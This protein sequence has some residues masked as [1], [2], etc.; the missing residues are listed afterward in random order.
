M[1]RELRATQARVD[2]GPGSAYGE[3]GSDSEDVL[4]VDPEEDP[5][6]EAMAQ[7]VGAGVLTHFLAPED[8]AEGEG[9][10]RQAGSSTDCWL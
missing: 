3:G 5:W 7:D 10:E 6:E 9:R 8:I 4:F 2:D 1:R